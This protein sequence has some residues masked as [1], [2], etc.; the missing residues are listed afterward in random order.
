VSGTEIRR[1][2]SRPI[3]APMGEVRASL[4]VRNESLRL[5]AVLDHHRKIGVDRFFV[6]DNGSTDG[7]VELLL[8]QPDVT[9]FASDAPFRTR[10]AYWRHALLEE[11]FSECW[12]L[13]LDADELFV[14][15]GMEEVGL[16]RFCEFL[17]R[18]K[19]AGVFAALIDM[20]AQESIERVPYR[21]GESLVERFPYFDR[22]GYHLRF[23]GVRHGRE[24]SP[25]FQLSGGPRERVFFSQRAPRW[26][27]ALARRLYDIRRTEPARV[28]QIPGLGPFLNKAARRAL[29]PYAPNCGKVP[30]LRWRRGDA[31]KVW[32][33]E[34]LHEVEPR[35]PLSHCWAALLHF[36]NIPGLRERVREAVEGRLY[37][38]ADREYDRYHQVLRD[39]GELVLYGPN[40]A[41]FTSTTDLL[42][43][44]LIRSTPAWEAVVVN[45]ATGGYVPK[46]PS[47][48]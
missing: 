36:K 22:T 16:H 42:E 15:P 31:L 13:H 19:V 9:L 8:E 21:P 29:P 32:C 12:G 2:D 40:S 34:A 38:D 28:V 33:L 47:P 48:G 26:S 46:L 35:I 45:E 5:P 25:A 7:T 4:V 43:T 23:R 10:K 27:R 1:I 17:A 3:P 11:F 14:Y 20:Y 39:R 30:L 24:V 6:V 18:E 37:G 44:G 41:R